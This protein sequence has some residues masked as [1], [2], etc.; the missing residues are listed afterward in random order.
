MARTERWVREKFLSES[1]SRGDFCVLFGNDDQYSLSSEESAP[2]QR[3]SPN[4]IYG[5]RKAEGLFE[6][7]NQEYQVTEMLET[8]ATSGNDTGRGK[9]MAMKWTYDVLLGIYLFFTLWG[10]VA[11]KQVSCSCSAT[12]FMMIDKY[13]TA[14]VLV[15]PANVISSVF[16][17]CNMNINSIFCGSVKALSRWNIVSI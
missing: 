16:Y 6:L 9:L 11:G 17:C 5:R 14:I 7:S 10:Y 4:G 12:E 2:L 13:Y 15:C 8:Y 3:R 1:T